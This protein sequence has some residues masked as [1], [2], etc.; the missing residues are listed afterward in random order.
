MNNLPI[1]AIVNKNIT[2]VLGVG[3]D[4]ITIDADLEND[5]GIDMLEAYPKIIKR[6]NQDLD[7][8][9]PLSDRY[10][11]RELKRAETVGELIEVVET[12]AEY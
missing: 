3:E 2:E 6:I 8:I 12:E 9:L 7:G 10:F 4:E 1:S 5:L 11:V